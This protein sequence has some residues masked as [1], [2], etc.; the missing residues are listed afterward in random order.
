[1]AAWGGAAGLRD[2]L[3][4][5]FALWAGESRRVSV[6]AAFLLEWR[7]MYLASRSRASWLGAGGVFVHLPGALALLSVV[8]VNGGHKLCRSAIK[9]APYYAGP[10]LL[11]LEGGISLQ[12]TTVDFSCGFNKGPL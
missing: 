7:G 12:M 8:L 5:L 10:R 6:R 9:T 3:I 2:P 4:D 1:M 11:F